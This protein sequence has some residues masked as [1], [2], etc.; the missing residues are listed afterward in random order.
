MLTK[1]ICFCAALAGMLGLAPR[2]EAQIVRINVGVDDS[3]YTNFI[4]AFEYDFVTEK[5]SFPGGDAKL[6]EFINTN[7]KYP[8]EAYEK[9]V[10]GRVTCGFIVNP[11]GSISNIHLLR[12]VNALL[13]EEAIRIFSLMP[14]WHPGRIDGIPV[15]VRVV[16]SIRFKK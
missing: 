9:G 14:P 3:G 4:E 5:P 11:D 8:R 15:P 12:S 13:N 6:L 1:L 2:A 10:Q 16:Q 7:R